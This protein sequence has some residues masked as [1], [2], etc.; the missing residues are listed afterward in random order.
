MIIE[1]ASQFFEQRNSELKHA[2]LAAPEQRGGVIELCQVMKI[3]DVFSAEI[4]SLKV[5]V[6][7]S[8]K[9]YITLYQLMMT[10]LPSFAFL[11]HSVAS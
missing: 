11:Y 7:V 10:M 8:K 6:L 3:R 9:K 5:L 4:R 2:F 1:S